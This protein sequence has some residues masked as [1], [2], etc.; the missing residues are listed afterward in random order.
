MAMTN[1]EKAE[2]GGNEDKTRVERAGA[3]KSGEMGLRETGYLQ[4]ANGVFQPDRAVAHRDE[5]YDQR[6]FDLLSEMQLRHFWYQGRHRFLFH[7]TTQALQGGRGSA[8]GLRVVDL[9]GGCGGWL[10]YLTDRWPVAFGEV[11][12]ADSS[13][14]ALNRAEKILPSAV[15]RYQID[16]LDLG[17]NQRWDVAYLLD[18]LEH[19]PE[20]E[21]AMAQV[22]RALKPGGVAIVTMPALQC[23]W[24]YNDEVA[25]HR[26]R[27]DRAG[28]ARLAKAAGLRLVTARYFM[29]FLS[30]LLWLSRA[31]PGVA[32]L[33]PQQKQEL[34]ERSHRIP[35]PI[36]NALLA[37]VFSLETPL[38]YQM[39][40]P[41][42]TSILGVF[43]KA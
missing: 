43:Q 14:T 30:P 26:R 1:S 41:W 3:L 21:A 27:Y 7:A 8:G 23:F 2:A 4:N 42:G 40:F 31:R 20:D 32:K 13:L 38:G 5:E 12:L 19:L 36:V 37:G 39:A 33:T 25:E 15:G 34:V 35:S 28:M 18:V 9:G 10:K 11:A 22:G 6:G 16:L 29:F 17:W 24:S